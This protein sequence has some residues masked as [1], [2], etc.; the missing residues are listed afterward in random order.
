[1]RFA[2]AL[3]R[4]RASVVCIDPFVGDVNMWL[5]NHLRLRPMLQMQVPR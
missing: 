2:R 3:Q 5:N 1:M 4:T